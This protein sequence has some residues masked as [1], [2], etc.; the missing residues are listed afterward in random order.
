VVRRIAFSPDGKWIA[1]GG[2]DSVR[3]FDARTGK[4]VHVYR[5]DG[6]YSFNVAFRPDSRRLALVGGD[7]KVKEWKVS[8][9]GRLEPLAVWDFNDRVLG[10][11]YSPDGRYLAAGVGGEVVVVDA[12]RG[13]GPLTLAG[14]AW[15]GS[16]LAFSPKGRQLAVACRDGAGRIYDLATGEPIHALPHSRSAVLSVAY[17]S[18]GSRL[19]SGG[20]DGLIKVWDVPTGKL[21]FAR[22]GHN[23]GSCRVVAFSPDGKRLAAAI[24]H[25]VTI[26][27]AATGEALRTFSGQTTDG[28]SLAFS[29]DGQHL[30]LVTSGRIVEFGTGGR[31]I[32]PEL[33]VCDLK[34]GNQVFALSLP[35]PIRNLTFSR[36]GRHLLIPGSEE[37][38]VK[39]LEATTG[40]EVRRFGDKVAPAG[41]LE[42]GSGSAEWRGIASLSLSPD[43]K[44]IAT[45]GIRGA[46]RIWDTTTGQ[47][48]LNLRGNAAGVIGLAFSPD[49]RRLASSDM[50]FTVK[51]FDAT[52][53]G[54]RPEVP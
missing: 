51:V 49:S 48:V 41:Y 47:S 42:I 1:T 34:T 50:S 43:G 18:D 32:S 35:S 40:Q 23:K 44:R 54:E 52:P 26:W 19:A 30:A 10:L 21:V 25:T 5:G 7:G 15:E 2:R 27:D 13:P 16:C 53:L 45:P 12:L 28:N 24:G 20:Y 6:S 31:K 39:I 22:G 11:A 33:K 4:Q 36:N 38:A 8:P 46:V 37:C 17:N 29:P 14:G 3:L 9:E